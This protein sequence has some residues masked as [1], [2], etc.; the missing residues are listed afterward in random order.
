[1]HGNFSHNVAVTSQN[2]GRVGSI[3]GALPVTPSKEN[4]GFGRTPSRTV[5]FSK[6]FDSPRFASN[7]ALASR[8][9]FAEQ[10]RSVNGQIHANA[11]RESVPVSHESVPNES[12]QRFDDSRGSSHA[13][14]ASERS[15][16]SARAPN[17]SERTS[18]ASEGSR[19]ER[20]ASSSWSRYSSERGNASVPVIYGDRYRG[21]YS[22]SE[23]SGSSY[24][25][26]SYPSYSHS[27]YPSYSHSSHPSSSHRHKLKN[28]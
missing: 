22:P 13:G 12:W 23:S 11:T 18:T 14:A 20:P 21:S 7:R 3:R 26:S 9:S 27:S 25:H 8:N 5:A 16:P 10:Q 24:S 6:A 2:A 15:A 1:V 19:Q 4:L 28:K 17:A